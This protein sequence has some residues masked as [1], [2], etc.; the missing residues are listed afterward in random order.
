MVL[1]AAGI[2]VLALALVAVL[3]GFFNRHK[4]V[5]DQ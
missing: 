3:T 2:V 1:I 5:L 4:A